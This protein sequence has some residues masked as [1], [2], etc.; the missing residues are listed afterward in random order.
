M[1][2][3][4]AFRPRR[5]AVVVAAVLAFAR[6]ATAQTPTVPDTARVRI[7]SIP[8]SLPQPRNAVVVL[9]RGYHQSVR[10]Y[11][12][13]YLL[14]GHDGGYRN[15]M[16]RTNLLAYTER[17]PLIIVLPDGA[18]SWYTNSA[19]RPDEK[20][21]DYVATD[22]PAY[23]DQNFRTLTFREARYVA[24]LSM[25][26]YGALKMGLKYPARF[27]L[28]GSFSGALAA[29]TST[30]STTVGEAFGPAGSAARAENDLVALAGSA[31]I[32]EGTYFYLDCGTADRLLEAN[33]T[34]AQALSARPLAYEYHEVAGVHSWEFWDRRLPVFMRLVEERIARLPAL[35]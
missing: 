7:V 12:V 33:R 20:F 6:I 22:I 16:E 25:G 13:L 28:S 29:P 14:H 4:R 5:I 1:P 27:S 26:G 15:W 2:A 11:P 8:G 18:N 9:P 17:M 35:D 19:A 23:V 3:R 10:R 24:G 34:F 21:E 32:P 30:T 31:R